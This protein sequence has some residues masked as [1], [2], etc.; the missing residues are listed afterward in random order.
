MLSRAL[1]M[2]ATKLQ[3]QY[4]DVLMRYAEMVGTENVPIGLLEFSTHTCHKEGDEIEMVKS[5]PDEELLRLQANVRQGMDELA[6]YLQ[7]MNN[8]ELQ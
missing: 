2:E 5:N 7:G 6:N 8:D 4:D 1:E 3:E